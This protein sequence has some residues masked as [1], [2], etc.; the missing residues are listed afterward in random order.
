MGLSREEQRELFQQG[1]GIEAI[2]HIEAL[3]DDEEEYE[4]EEEGGRAGSMG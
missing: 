4:A 1:G 3:S 2:T